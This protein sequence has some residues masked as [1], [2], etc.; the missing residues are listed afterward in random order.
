[1]SELAAE[2]LEF[3][4][5]EGEPISYFY[6]SA[7]KILD[8]Y[9]GKNKDVLVDVGAHIGVVD[10]LAVRERNWG[11]C[12]GI[13][14]NLPNYVRFLDNV[15]INHCEGK[16][17]P[18]WAAIS[19]KSF[20][21]GTLYSNGQGINSGVQS[22][23]FTDIYPAENV[24]LITLKDI[25]GNIPKIDLLK[26]DIEGGE[27]ALFTDENREIFERV[28]WIDVELHNFELD[29][30]WHGILYK[31]KGNTKAKAKKYLESCG[32][33]LSWEQVGWFGPRR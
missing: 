17:L 10:I 4:I 7:T 9:E 14:A 27:W 13:E 11:F 31:D 29:K 1:M 5:Q 20:Q 28:Q 23:V 21:Q 32:F 3:N 22:L 18:I 16:I 24:C 26:I 12:V 19:D 8:R 2:K 33:K 15:N 30:D 25:I 6:E